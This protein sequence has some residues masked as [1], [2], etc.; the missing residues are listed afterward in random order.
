VRA[1]AALGVPPARCVVIG[2]IGPDMSAA[3]AAGATGML[4]PGPA[5]RAEEIAQAPSV[6]RSLD[7]AVDA[8][9]GGRS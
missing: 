2:D 1:A 9:L 5:T 3:R 6:Y 7:E 8:V 4:V